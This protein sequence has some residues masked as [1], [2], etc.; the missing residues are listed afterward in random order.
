MGRAR[1]RHTADASAARGIGENEKKIVEL[2]Y[3]L[4]HALF[5]LL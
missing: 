3:E 4:F 1:K 2:Q 5:M